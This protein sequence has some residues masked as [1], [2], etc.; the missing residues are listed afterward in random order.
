M[1]RRHK[2]EQWLQAQLEETVKAY[3]IEHIVQKT[4]KAV[5]AKIREEAKKR[6]LVEEKKKKKQMEYLKQLQ[7]KV[8]VEDTAFM[9]ILKVLRL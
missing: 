5:G 8:L 9:G 6:R 4:R 3:Y 1:Q 2:E 7:D